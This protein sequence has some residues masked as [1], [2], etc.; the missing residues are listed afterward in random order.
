MYRRA[1]QIVKHYFPRFSCIMFIISYTF[2]FYLVSSFKLRVT[3]LPGKA[4]DSFFP[5]SNAG[6]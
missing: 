4:S 5:Y 6:L 1:A 3:F 2:Y